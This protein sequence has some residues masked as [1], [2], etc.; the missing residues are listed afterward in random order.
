M[1]IV[2]DH[3]TGGSLQSLIEEL[4]EYGDHPTGLARLSG[5]IHT[6]RSLPGTQSEWLRGR[7]QRGWGQTAIDA[8]AAA[9]EG[10]P[11]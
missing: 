8:M 6:V 5:E 10:A 2:M 9:A 7:L 1:A 4:T 3:V 11:S